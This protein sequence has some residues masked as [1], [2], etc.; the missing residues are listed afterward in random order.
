MC[1]SISSLNSRTIPE[2]HENEG[3]ANIDTETSSST[4]VCVIC[5]DFA[6]FHNYGVKTCEGCKGFFKRTVFQ[7]KQKTYVCA[8][9]KNCVMDKRRRAVCPYCRF[10]KCISSG[11]VSY[12]PFIFIYTNTF[13][14][15]Y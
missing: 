8:S 1:L 4:S 15:Y 2:E 11:M 3:P 7:K 14:I 5:G 6:A 10:Q 12:Y 9:N 13:V